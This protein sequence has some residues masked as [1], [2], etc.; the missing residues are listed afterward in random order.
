M[1]GINVKIQHDSRGHKEN[2]Q[3]AGYFSAPDALSTF[4]GD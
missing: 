2:D 3:R 1:L 4:V